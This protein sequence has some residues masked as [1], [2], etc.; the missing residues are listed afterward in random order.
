MALN[1][2]DNGRW[3]ENQL[4]ISMINHSVPVENGKDLFYFEEGGGSVYLISSGKVDLLRKLDN[5]IVHTFFQE[6]VVGFVEIFNPSGKHYLVRYPGTRLYRISSEHALQIIEAGNFWELLARYF[7][8][9][10]L[11]MIN[12]DYHLLRRNHKDVVIN[13]LIELDR[14]RQAG[15]ENVNIIDYICHRS[16]IS[17]S[18][19]SIILRDLKDKGVI[20][21]D[22][23]K[24]LAIK[25]LQMT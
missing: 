18:S 8:R 4:F 24:L 19:V 20:I 3:T 5:L 11:M 21:V 13:H 12:R 17:S 2:T 10:L 14:L 23:G 7:S 15:K 25:H 1:D 9:H 16:I 6:E 22:N